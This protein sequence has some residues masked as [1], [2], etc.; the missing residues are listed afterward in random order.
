MFTLA[1]LIFLNSTSASSMILSVAGH[2][3]HSS[4]DTT[5]IERLPYK[6]VDETKIYSWF[7]VLNAGLEIY[8]N[9]SW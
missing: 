9:W 3:G 5:Y 4:M 1:L 8:R 7:S 6:F 2:V